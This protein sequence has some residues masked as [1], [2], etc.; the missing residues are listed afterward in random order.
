MIHCVQYYN[1]KQHF[2]SWTQFQRMKAL[3]VGCRSGLDYIRRSIGYIVNDFKDAL[4]APKKALGKMIP[5]P[6]TYGTP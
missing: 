2:S 5:V 4:S 1:G 3:T 6:L